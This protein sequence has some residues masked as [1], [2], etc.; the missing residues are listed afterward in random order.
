ARAVLR[1]PRVEDHLVNLILDIVGQHE[2]QHVMRARLKNVTEHR[3]GRVR[4]GRLRS[5]SASCYLESKLADRKEYLRDRLLIDRVDKVG[6]NDGHLVN[7]T[8][9][10]FLD[11]E[12]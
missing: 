7:L 1:S 8:A 6:V 3:I 5:G 4:F 2:I 10:K 11:A 12:S 9:E